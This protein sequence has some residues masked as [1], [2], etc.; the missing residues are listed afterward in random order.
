MSMGHTRPL[1][2]LFMCL[3]TTN[4]ACAIEMIDALIAERGVTECSSSGSS[5]GSTT[6]TN[7][8]TTSASDTSSGTTELEVSTS[9]AEAST[10]STDPE[11]ETG[12]SSS[13]PTPSVCGNGILEGDETCDDGNDASNDGCQ[14]CAKD[15]IVFVSSEYYQGY[16][17]QGLYGAD[18]RCRSLAGKAGLPNHLSYMAWLSTPTTPA[19][20]RLLHSKGRYV[21]VNG[22]VVAQDWDALISG[23]LENPIIVDEM[24]QTKDD[25][26][27]TGTLFTG[28]PALGSEF[29]D[30][31]ED[32]GAFEQAG[33]GSSMSV[34]ANW[35]F[36]DYEP[37]GSEARLYCI[38]Q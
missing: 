28:E 1:V 33:V 36:F 18:Q 8:G 5:G 31:W 32:S 29:C 9:S 4:F 11:T 3:G 14:E 26:V 12:S 15:S 25:A 21:L 38:E 24:S 10:T 7:S 23:A 17:L 37:C 27:W 6:S 13:G 16:T 20:E 35:S 34:D 30:D 19:V 22:L 2:A